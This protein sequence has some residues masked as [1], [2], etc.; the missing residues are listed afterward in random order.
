MATVLLL[1]EREK[2]FGIGAGRML[3]VLCVTVLISVL[4]NLN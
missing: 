1:G 2:H 3:R 4:L